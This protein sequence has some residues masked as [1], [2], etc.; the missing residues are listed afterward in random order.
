MDR[1]FS[2]CNK[3]E[4]GSLLPDM[5]ALFLLVWLDP[6]VQ[7][8]Y[9][10]KGRKELMNSGIIRNI[11]LQFFYLS[12]M[13]NNSRRRFLQSASLGAMSLSLGFDSDLF[14]TLKMKKKY[15]LQLFTIPAMASKDFKGTL[16][17]ISNIGYKEIEF[18]GP[19]PFSAPETIE[20]WKTMS[21]QLGIKQN[22]FYGYSTKETAKLL[23]EYHLSSPSMHLDMMTF[24][25][26]MSPM[27]DAAAELGVKYVINPALWEDERKT[28]DDFKRRAEEFNQFG[29][30][31]KP[32]G[33]R[34][35]YH[36]HGYEEA[37]K[38]HVIPF[39]LLL[40]KT[41]PD[42]VA[43]EMDVFWM[44]AS[45]ANPIEYLRAYPGRFKL[46]H[47]KDAS[48]PVRFSGDGGSAD[49]WI[50]LFPK[51]SDP[52]EGVFDISKVVQQGLVSGME[53]FYL[54]RDLAADPEK[55]LRNSFKNLNAIDW[56]K[57]AS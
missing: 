13:K 2:F 17:L 24:R 10:N 22:A 46:A 30:Q 7:F 20:Q 25:K 18:F 42:L 9:E 3:P 52:G 26:N 6:F 57:K 32:Y 48:E 15:G 55:T 23:K 49:Q 1:A 28:L 45:G 56:N 12:V 16:E 40:E 51:M 21:S 54:E 27:L 11:F 47:L 44:K 4:A 14:K 38:E 39:H 29:L 50:A 53:H 8:H 5:Q 37:P 35:G 34:F 36:N 41:D 33:I 31:M 19:Y 43:F